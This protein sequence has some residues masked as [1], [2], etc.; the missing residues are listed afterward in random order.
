MRRV[1]GAFVLTAGLLWAVPA[2]A[3]FILAGTIGGVNFCASDNNLGCG[4][5]APLVDIDPT[6]G[7]ISLAPALIGGLDVQGSL[8]TEQI[9]TH[10]VLNSGSLLIVNNTGA[11]V[12]GQLAVGGTGFF[13]PITQASISGSGTWEDAAG[14]TTTLRWFDD[15]NNTQGA[16][17]PFAGQPGILLG[18]FSD[19]AGI[20]TDSYSFTNTNIAVIDPLR[21]GMTL[22]FDLSLASGGSLVSRG[23]TEIKDQ[24]LVPEP[25]SIA[26]MGM[27]LLG[28]GARLRRRYSL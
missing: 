21:F 11:T 4:F 24:A 15:P 9:G 25:A 19:T 16:L 6:L 5:G 3:A 17:N 27:G 22:Q 10:N 23:M 13:G 7:R 14:S 2:H 26:L 12:T 8:H 1:V 20:G 18:T 28:V